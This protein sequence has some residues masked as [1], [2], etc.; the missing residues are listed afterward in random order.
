[1]QARL[2][3]ISNSAASIHKE[4]KQ[5]CFQCQKSHTATKL[6]RSV[7]KLMRSVAKLMRSIAKLMKS[8]AKLM[9]S[10]AKLMSPV[11]QKIMGSV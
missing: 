10:V 8:V 7:A 11:A 5:A 1:M 2:I 6:M 4:Q 9:R 3:S